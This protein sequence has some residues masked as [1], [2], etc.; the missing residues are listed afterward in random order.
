MVRNMVAGLPGAGTDQVRR[1]QGLSMDNESL[2]STM[3]LVL[4]GA[5]TLA[6]FGF[7]LVT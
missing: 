6:M 5:L 1:G 2:G 4:A 7:A 3:G